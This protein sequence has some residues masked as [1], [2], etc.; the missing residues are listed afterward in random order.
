MKSPEPNERGSYHM[1]HKHQCIPANVIDDLSSYSTSYRGR[2]FEDR[3]DSDTWAA[4]AED[5]EDRAAV[6]YVLQ[7]YQRPAIMQVV[8]RVAMVY[9]QEYEHEYRGFGRPRREWLVSIDH[10]AL[11]QLPFLPEAVPEEFEDILANTEEKAR[12]YENIP[13]LVVNVSRFHPTNEKRF[14]QYMFAQEH[15]RN[16]VEGFKATTELDWTKFN[17]KR[18]RAVIIDL[19]KQMDDVESAEEYLYSMAENMES[20]G[21]S[22]DLLCIAGART[23]HSIVSPVGAKKWRAKQDFENDEKLVD[24]GYTWRLNPIPIL[25]GVIKPGGRLVFV[26][27]DLGETYLDPS[28]CEFDELSLVM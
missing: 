4:E 8:R 23:C 15:Y 5:R 19:R 13:I 2:N 6:R 24:D 14:S 27:S 28:P 22:L 26:D 10:R 25:K 3:M 21:L 16:I 20:A 17:P 12:F 9:G 1:N 18:L 11:R 7:G